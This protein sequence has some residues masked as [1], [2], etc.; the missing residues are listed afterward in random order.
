MPVENFP[1]QTSH[2]FPPE[3]LPGSC[4]LLSEP[5]VTSLQPTSISWPKC[6]S[7]STNYAIS[8][9]KFPL[10]RPIPVRKGTPLSYPIPVDV[11]ISWKAYRLWPAP[12]S[13]NLFCFA[14]LFCLLRSQQKNVPHFR[15]FVVLFVFSSLDNWAYIIQPV[16]DTSL[17]FWGECKTGIVPGNVRR[18][19]CVWERNCPGKRPAGFLCVGECP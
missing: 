13:K 15:Y 14:L 6:Y 9:V 4:S 19:F 3:D 8:N 16:C 2:I 7:E 1:E 5:G 18:D 11:Y 17:A 12:L 10:P